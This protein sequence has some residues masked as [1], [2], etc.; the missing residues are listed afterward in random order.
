M[1][2]SRGFYRGNA[3]FLR[4]CLRY[5]AQ[6]GTEII[7][8]DWPHREARGVQASRF[9]QISG[10]LLSMNPWLQLRLWELAVLPL[11]QLPG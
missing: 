1:A 8:I 10:W 5:A 9:S 3:T 7:N 6:E 4:I 2:H 11:A